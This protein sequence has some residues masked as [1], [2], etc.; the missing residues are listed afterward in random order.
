MRDNF[1]TQLTF[2]EAAS[3]VDTI[4]AANRL[5]TE[6]LAIARTHQRILAQD[7]VAPM[8]LPPFDNSAMDGYAVR[9]ADVANG[10]TTLR[11]VGEQFAGRALGLRI[12]AGECIRIT[13]GAPMP[14]GAD[15][16]V[17]REVVRVDGDNI[18]IPAGIRAQ[19][20]VRLAGEDVRTGDAILAPG[21]LLTPARVATVA[22]LGIDQ[23]T[24]SAR[25]T[26]AVFTTGDELVPPGL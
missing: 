7:V 6:R 23:L 25:P 26:V 22:S 3:I 10:E 21:Q 5:P 18:A 8:P 15:T 1:P 4:A 13:T 16:V 20:N 19:A 14:E 11:L 24:V 12:D 17:I 9:H 2:D